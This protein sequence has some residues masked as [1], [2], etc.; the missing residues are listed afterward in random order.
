MLELEE[1]FNKYN[2]HVDYNNE[3]TL[4]ITRSKERKED[5]VHPSFTCPHL[6]HRHYRLEIKKML[7][8][9]IH[10]SK[11]ERGYMCIQNTTKSCKKREKNTIFPTFTCHT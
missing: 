5:I 1:C 7:I 3:P 4:K 8:K 10:K 2:N 6:C 9:E 11:K